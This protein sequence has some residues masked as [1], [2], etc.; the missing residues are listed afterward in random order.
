MG[1]QISARP[2]NCK[3]LLNEELEL[4]IFPGIL[5]ITVSIII[6]WVFFAWKVDIERIFNDFIMY[7]TEGEKISGSKT[8]NSAKINR[9]AGSGL[10]ELLLAIYIIYETLLHEFNIIYS[11]D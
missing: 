4:T 11:T 6:V 10:I 7:L 5:W 3:S 8:R 2:K 9:T 1:K